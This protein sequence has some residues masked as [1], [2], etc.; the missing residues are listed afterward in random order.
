[1]SGIV[2]HII[3]RSFKSGTV[4]NNWL[5]SIVTPIPKCKNPKISDYRP[6]SVTPILSRLTEKLLVRT[7]IKP[8]LPP[9]ELN[10]QYAYKN[11]GSTTCAI[12]KLLDFITSSFENGSEYV[13]C[14]FVDFSKAFDT[15]DHVILIDKLDK[16]DIPQNIRNWIV[17]FLTGRSQVVKF[18]GTLSRKTTINRGIV[19]GSALGPYL[20]LIFQMDLKPIGRSNCLVKYADD[21]ILAVPSGS[22]ITLQQEFENQVGWAR[23]NKQTINI[24]KNKEV[25]F[26]LSKSTKN[27]TQTFSDIELVDNFNLLGILIS[28]N[29]DFTSHVDFILSTISQRFYLLN[30]LKLQGLT[31]D[32]LDTIFPL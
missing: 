28:N 21:D 27:K 4:P 5:I 17:R 26:S 30:M 9:F 15:V 10:D 22:D 6:I 11:T 31:I 29:L 13:R 7:F 23:I 16:L 18:N 20:Y 3:N 8:A 25:I 19:Q 1:M 12:I 14:L 2:A 24:L 32:G